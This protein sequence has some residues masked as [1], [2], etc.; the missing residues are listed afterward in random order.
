MARTTIQKRIINTKVTGFIIKDGAPVQVEYTIGKRVG[1]N[2]A[3]S[4]IRKEEPSFAAVA[5]EEESH[6]Y[7]MKVEDFI[8]HAYIADDEGEDDED[9]E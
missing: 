4:L 5:V 8:K 7:K 6:L 9:E 3:Q 1:L 2:S